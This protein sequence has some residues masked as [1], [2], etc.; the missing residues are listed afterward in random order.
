MTQATPK[1]KAMFFALAHN[2]GYP[3]G[4][5]KERAKQRY[6]L[7]SFNDMTTE[8]LGALIDRL[9]ERQGKRAQGSAEETDQPGR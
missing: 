8:Q 6:G 7:A 2:L 9:V 1:Q 4:L 3:A 5:V